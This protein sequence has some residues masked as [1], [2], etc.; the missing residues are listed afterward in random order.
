MSTR[1]LVSV[2][3]SLTRLNH[4]ADKLFDAIVVEVLHRG[5]ENFEL[6]G[7]AQLA[8]ALTEIKHFDVM[9]D[10]LMDAIAVTC[11]KSMDKLTFEELGTCRLCALC[12]YTSSVLVDLLWA[13]AHH[14]HFHHDAKL[15]E[16]LANGLV[17]R[18]D[19]AKPLTSTTCVKLCE[20]VSASDLGP[21]NS[22]RVLNAVASQAAQTMADLSKDELLTVATGCR[23]ARFVCDQLL[24]SLRDAFERHHEELSLSDLCCILNEF[25]SLDFYPGSTLQDMALQKISH[26]DNLSPTEVCEYTDCT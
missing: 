12:N 1:D 13:Y 19:S 22:C 11:K 9:T 18:L 7:L 14:M 5:T 26:T 10:I 21:E 8:A 16:C 15:V 23:K 20:V 17:D 24:G 2:V 6:S 25:T 3:A 4:R